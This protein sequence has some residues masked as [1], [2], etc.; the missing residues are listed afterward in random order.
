MEMLFTVRLPVTTKSF[1]DVPPLN[2]MAFVVVFP[3]FVTVW[4]LAAVELGQLVPFKRQTDE[5]F[6]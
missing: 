5:P 2:T 6:T 1:V 4:K 3:A